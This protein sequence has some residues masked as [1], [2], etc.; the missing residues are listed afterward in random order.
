MWLTCKLHTVR[1]PIHETPIFLLILD[2]EPKSLEDYGI[3]WIRLSVL[4]ISRHSSTTFPRNTQAPRFFW[5]GP[6][7]LRGSRPSYGLCWTIKKVSELV[8]RSS[9][10][11]LDSG[12]VSN[13]K[14]LNLLI[15]LDKN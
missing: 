14:I 13:D 5:D 8:T 6:S 10:L 1:D 9:V 15:D 11:S 3:P 2:Q 4:F 12:V 7:Y